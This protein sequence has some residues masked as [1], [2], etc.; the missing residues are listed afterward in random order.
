ME[1]KPN[2]S[3]IS[4]TLLCVLNMTKSDFGLSRAI[5]DSR[6]IELIKTII[7]KSEKNIKL[8]NY[9]FNDFYFLIPFLSYLKRAFT[10][11]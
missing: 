11:N 10:I 1:E 3:L 9:S 2:N 6:A 8:V 4:A 7:Q 5:S